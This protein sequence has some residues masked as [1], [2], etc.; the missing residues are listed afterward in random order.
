M[1]NT[2]DARPGPINPPPGWYSDPSGQPQK[3]WWDGSAWQDATQQY[4]TAGSATI[5][6]DHPVDPSIDIWTVNAWLISLSPLTLIALRLAGSILGQGTEASV[7]TLV[8]V[9][10]M[11]LLPVVFGFFDYRSLQLRGIDRPFH[12]AWGFFGTVVYVAGRAAVAHRRTGHGLGP[13][14]VFL[15]ACVGSVAGLI[16]ESVARA[17]SV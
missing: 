15:G 3:R 6:G 5:T 14:W 7:V 2:I 9:Y 16:L 8:G 17:A 1:S 12:W 11:I 10:S 4:V 13:L